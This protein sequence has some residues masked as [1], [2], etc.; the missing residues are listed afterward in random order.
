MFA[1]IAFTATRFVRT[2]AGLIASW[3]RFRKVRLNFLEDSLVRYGSLKI[4]WGSKDL[5]EGGKRIYRVIHQ[6]LTTTV[7]YTSAVKMQSETE[8]PVI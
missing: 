6:V 1:Y 3:E 7:A 4:I 8:C 5:K 2:L